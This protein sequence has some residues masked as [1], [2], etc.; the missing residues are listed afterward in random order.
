MNIGIDK[1]GFAMPDYYLNIEDLALKRGV[2]PEKFTKGFMQLEMS[3]A[4][5]TQ[6]IVTLGARAAYEILTDEDKEKIDMIIV[7]T[8][9]GID[10]SK[11]ASVFIHSL[12]NIQKFARSVEIKEACYGATAAL[13]FARNHIVSKPNSYVLVIA[14]DIAKYGIN[15]GGESTQG[16]GSVAMLIKQNPSIALINNDNVYQTRDLMDF[17]RPNYSPY[18]F[19]DGKFSTELYLDCLTTTWE[20]YLEKNKKN[21]SDF[22]AICFHLPYPKLGL[23]GL[24]AITSNIEEDKK[25][26]LEANFTAS[27]LYSQR[28]GNI[29]TGSLFLGL[30]SLLEN[31]KNLKAGNNIALYSYGSGAVCEIFSLTLVK[32]FDLK[33]RKNRLTSDF[34]NRTRLDI[35]Q[36]EEIFFKTIDLD[37]NGSASFD[38]KS[39]FALQK[40]ENHKRIYN[41]N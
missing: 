38:D 20:K 29:Y 16:A 39:K 6:D 17:W 24:Q 30:L 10:Q 12:L 4:P 25:N 36:Y 18:P 7:G 34:A 11:A 28:V 3:I 8:E 19:V 15:S 26:K 32:D 1:I 37:E 21:Y 5:H 40:I 13:E 14:S 27:I 23:K 2:E 33:L 9:T 35:D 31:S 22:V 41:K